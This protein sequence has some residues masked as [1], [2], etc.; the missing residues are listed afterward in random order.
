MY[1]KESVMSRN[2]SKVYTRTGDSGESS[3][4]GGKRLPKD[5][6]RFEAMGTVDELNAYVGNA[7]TILI[8]SKNESDDK[9]EEAMSQILLSIQNELFS[10]CSILATPAETPYEGMPEISPTQ[11]EAIESYID[12][13]QNEV[14]PLKGFTLPGGTM[15]NAALHQCRTICR[16]AEREIIR[17]SRKEKVTPAIL[18]YINRLSDLFFVLSRYVMK[19]AGKQEQI[20]SK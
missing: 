12:S 20:W 13:Y 4:V 18:M 7:A 2:I 8:N 3:L 1:G 17:L 5:D 19:R 11:I 14:G 15:E 9:S 6:Q 16:R 10:I